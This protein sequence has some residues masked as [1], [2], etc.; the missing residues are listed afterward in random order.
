MLYEVITSG[1]KGSRNENIRKASLPQ[2]SDFSFDLS[3]ISEI[4]AGVASFSDVT[5]KAVKDGIKAIETAMNGEKSVAEAE[6]AIKKVTGTVKEIADSIGQLEASSN[7]IGII[8]NTIT[9]IASKTNLLARNN[10]V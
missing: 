8:T 7:K 3:G 5:D 9:E 6:H 2:N 1:S 4:A 10:F